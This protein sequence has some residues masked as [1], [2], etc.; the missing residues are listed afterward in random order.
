MYNLWTLCTNALQLMWLSFPSVR[1]PF[2]PVS[3]SW[4]VN[5]S[6][7]SGL[8]KFLFDFLFIPLC[9]NMQLM[10]KSKFKLGFMLAVGKK[11]SSICRKTNKQTELV[12]LFSASLQI[13]ESICSVP[14]TFYIKTW[15][16]WSVHWWNRLFF[17]EVC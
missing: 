5:L 1:A 15:S 17:D 9:T 13:K 16:F 11:G 10:R 7:G 6:K 2:C 4:C 12:R 14:Q 8:L 3:D